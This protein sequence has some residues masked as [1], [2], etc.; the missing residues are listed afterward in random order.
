MKK[1]AA[2]FVWK[3]ELMEKVA[4]HWVKFDNGQ[5]R[6]GPTVVVDLALGRLDRRIE[7]QRK[8]A[9]FVNTLGPW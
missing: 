6:T 8:L 1:S 7:Q 5:A 3:W 2:L 9:F 4:M